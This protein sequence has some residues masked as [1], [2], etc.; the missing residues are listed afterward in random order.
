[1]RGISIKAVFLGGLTDIVASTILGI[2]LGI[3]VVTSHSL[4]NLHKDALRSAVVAAVHASPSLYAAQLLIGFG[5]SILGGFVAA[6]LAKENKRLNAILAAWLCVGIGIRAL[7][8]GQDG[9]SPVVVAFMIALT[10]LCYLVGASFQ[11]S[12]AASRSSPA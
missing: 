4:T 3:Y 10:P 1:M 5:S 11:A 2:P 8:T 6:Y 9:I 12:R 7:V